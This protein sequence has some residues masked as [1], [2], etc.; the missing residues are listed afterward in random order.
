[1][2]TNKSFID[3]LDSIINKFTSS[4]SSDKPE[5]KEATTDS[6]IIPVVEE[7]TTVE[8]TTNEETDYGDSRT[9]EEI[10]REDRED[11]RREQELR[12]TLQRNI[13][14]HGPIQANA[15]E[16]DDY[17]ARHSSDRK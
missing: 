3:P 10:E 7:A 6:T 16:Y 4:Q 15:S 12:D 5:T 14:R 13:E 2:D 17:V 1:M 8:E 11:E 9:L